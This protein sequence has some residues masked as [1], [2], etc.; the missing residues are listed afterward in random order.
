VNPHL[1]IP[2]KIEFE[3][4]VKPVAAPKITTEE[5]ELEVEFWTGIFKDRPNLFEKNEL[6]TRLA[7]QNFKYGEGKSLFSPEDLEEEMAEIKEALALFDKIR[8]AN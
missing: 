2:Y 1:K 8:M 3:L 5:E 6:I 7:L 4:A